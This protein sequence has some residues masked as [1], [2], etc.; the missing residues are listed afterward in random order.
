MKENGNIAFRNPHFKISK[1]IRP[2]SVAEGDSGMKPG[3]ASLL[4]IGIRLRRCEK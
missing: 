1:R 2:M 3:F 4:G